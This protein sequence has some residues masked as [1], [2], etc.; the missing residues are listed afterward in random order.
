MRLEGKVAIVTGA[1]R[2]L[3]KA[4]C[5]RLA[6][7]GAKVVATDIIDTAGTVQE[8]ESQDGTAIG[9]NVDVTSAQDTLR[10]AEETVA[11][12]GRI[13]VLVNNAGALYG[14]QR[15]TFEDIDPQLWDKVMAVNVKGVWLC[16]SA[17]VPQMKKQGKGKIINISSVSA[18]R[19]ASRLMHYVASKGA[20]ISMT[21]AMAVE[22][23]D[24]N[25]CVN[26]VAPGFTITE[27]SFFVRSLEQAVKTAQ[28]KQDLKRPLHPEDLTGTIAFLAS[29]DADMITG[30][31]IIVDGGEVKH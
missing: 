20:V 24:Y 19:G 5:L 8:I 18:F 31:T 23:G 6:Q 26:S 3:G 7:E 29:D 15:M 27:A 22:L 9:L 17:V 16:A 21:Y 1:G 2:G 30:Q 13:D 11:K 25:I 10:M 28:A 12:F 14:L 4:Y